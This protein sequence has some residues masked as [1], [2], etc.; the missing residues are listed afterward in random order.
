MGK[1]PIGSIVVFR[2]FGLHLGHARVDKGVKRQFEPERTK[3]YPYYITFEPSSLS[4]FPRRVSISEFRRIY[5]HPFFTRAYLD[6][7]IDE[8]RNLVRLSGAQP[9]V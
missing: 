4:L 7:T 5:P 6:M 3:V 1:V 9:L 2:F 8:Y